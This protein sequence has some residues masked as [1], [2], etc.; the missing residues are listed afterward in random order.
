M[1]ISF[2]LDVLYLK[3]AS[4][5]AAKKDVRTFLNGIYFDFTQQTVQASNGYLMFVSHPKTFTFSDENIVQKGF[6]LSNEAIKHLLAIKVDNKKPETRLC[7]FEFEPQTGKI[8]V[9]LNN[10][11]MT[12]DDYLDGRK[13][14]D[15]IK[16]Y[17]E[18]HRTKTMSVKTTT[19][20]PDYLDIA[21]KA[22]KAL[23]P[24]TSNEAYF[25][26]HNFKDRMMISL[27][28]NLAQMLIMGITRQEGEGD[29]PFY[30][31]EENE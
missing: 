2:T 9:S 6:L 8:T 10:V 17:Q 15:I 13:Y 23:V 4:F 1:T 22:H 16:L 5:A 27:A 24:L 29:Y 25:S 14:P 31:W 21:I 28:N 20:H 18:T 3:S 26:Y 11:T 30:Q 12:F 19:Y 7:Q